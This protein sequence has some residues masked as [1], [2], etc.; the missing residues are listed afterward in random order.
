[1]KD[2]LF[3]APNVIGV[4]S[5]LIPKPVPDAEAW[6]IVKLAPPL[7]VNVT[8]WV[9]VLPVATEPK[10]TDEG[11]ALICPCTPLPDKAI[12]IGEF[13]ALLAIEIVP[14]RLPAV[15]GANCAAKLVL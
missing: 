11:L 2:V 1:V 15:V 5:P 8:V 4:V 9:P 7:L 14:L 12:A 3:P 6:V 13:G 10:V